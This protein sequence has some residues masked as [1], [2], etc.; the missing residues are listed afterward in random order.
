[1]DLPVVV[2]THLRHLLATI[3]GDE[4]A[5]VARLSALT[6]DLRLVAGSYRGLRLTV[7]Q[8]GWPVTL[9]S[10]AGTDHQ[11]LGASL[12]LPLSALDRSFGEEGSIVFYAE[13]PGAFVDLA[14]DL[15]YAL[16][17]ELDT[18]SL[19][20]AVDGDGHADGD[21][22]GSRS[23]EAARDG[24]RRSIDLDHDLPPVSRVSGLFGLTEYSD[25]NRAIG[26]LIAQGH[27][28]AE[29]D[30]E[31]RRRAASAGLAPYSYAR[32]L[33]ADYD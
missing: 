10:F 13:K 11:H 28:R 1:M 33:L 7:V 8:H 17:V 2:V 18:D 30:L 23:A 4:D 20:L 27:A 3:G 22:D 32:R 6:A 16:S 9:I 5:L 24:H 21:G 12:R 25:I 26:T 15:S 31:L 19:S 14:A 29:A